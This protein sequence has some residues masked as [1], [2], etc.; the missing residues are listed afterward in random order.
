MNYASEFNEILTALSNNSTLRTKVIGLIETKPINNKAIEEKERE[1][2]FKS[3]LKTLVNR[4]ILG[5]EYT[6]TKISENIPASESKYANN[7]S[8]FS[9]DWEEKLVRT[10]LSRFYNH[11]VLEELQENG[12]LECFIPSAESEFQN[13]SCMHAKDTTCNINE[14]LQNLIDHYEFGKNNASLKIP[15]HPHCNHVVRPLSYADKLT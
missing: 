7:P 8:V 14:L 9:K 10:H 15:E 1:E 6:Y 2:K 13:F 12:K 5:L 3:I 4:D 11:A